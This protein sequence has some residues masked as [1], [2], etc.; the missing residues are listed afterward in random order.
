[1]HLRTFRNLWVGQALANMGDVLYIVGLISLVYN[2]TGSPLFMTAVPLIITFSRFISSLLAPLLLN[3]S[4]MRILIAYSQMGKT[5]LLILFVF[6]ILL[7][8]WVHLVIFNMCQYH[9]LFRWMGLTCSKC[10][11]SIYRQT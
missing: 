7:F 5:V 4:E 2:I 6:L 10:L 1:M 3:R 11:C 8:S 9:L